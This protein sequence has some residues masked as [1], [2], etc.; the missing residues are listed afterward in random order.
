MTFHYDDIIVGA[1]SAGAVLAARLSEDPARRV[2]VLEAGPDFPTLEST[3][4]DILN[5][6][7]MSLNDH[8]WQFRADI[9]DGRRIRFPRAKLT[10]GSSGVT[11]TVALRGVPADYD[12]WAHLGNP[13]WAWSEVLPRFIRMEDDVDFGDGEFHGRGG[14]FPIRRFPNE[15]LTTLQRGFVTACLDAGYPEVKDHNHPEATG[16]GSIPSS[17]WDDLPS[18]RVN[19]AMTYLRAARGRQNLTIRAGVLVHEVTF[20]GTRAT[21]VLASTDGGPAEQITARRVILA[22]G[23]VASPMILMRSGIGPSD[24]LR[25]HGIDVRADVPGVGANLIDHPRSG[26]FMTPQPGAFDPTEP[27]LQEILRTTSATNGEFNDLQF[28]MVNHF[29]LT[30]FPE[31]QMLAG[32]TTILGVM[33]VH[34]RPKSRGRLTLTSADPA[35][36]PDVQL[37]FLDVKEDYDVLVEGVRTAFQLANH[38]EVRKYGANLVVLREDMADN[39]DMLRFYVKASLD[40]AYHPVGTAR[41]G[42]SDD[43]GAV[44]S[45]RGAV[46]GFESLYVCDASIMPNI[47]RCNT[48]P[49]S[50]MIGE[51]TSDW[52]RED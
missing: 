17:R 35:A 23:A 52:L 45:E 34:Q 1:G 13:G 49:T 21:G 15:E 47:V 40:S 18:V 41:M 24:E 5:G 14:P 39:D 9:H 3:P 42:T 16:V 12:E 11:A 27:F 46:H 31:L 8:D 4:P 19:T 20:D 22:A 29:D 48:N 38:A 32:G 7:A 37:N 6:S 28:Y 10:G 25:R 33:M 44:V 26:V 50:I 43:E 51:R 36:A 2:L 30:L